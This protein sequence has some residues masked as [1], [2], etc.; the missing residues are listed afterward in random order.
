V[1]SVETQM[2]LLGTALMNTVQQIMLLFFDLVPQLLGMACIIIG[3]L[4]K[5][6]WAFIRFHKRREDKRSTRDHEQEELM[7]EKGLALERQILEGA[8]ES[9]MPLGRLEEELVAAA[10]DGP[11]APSAPSALV[12]SAPQAPPR[13][14]FQC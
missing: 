10:A 11:S 3:I 6:T 4:W 1:L 9:P 12:G 14:V 2:I 13:Q 5:L 8:A 7:E